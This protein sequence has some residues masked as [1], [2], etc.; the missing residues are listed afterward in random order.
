MVYCSHRVCMGVGSWPQS[1][2]TKQTIFD[3]TLDIRSWLR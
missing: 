2:L 3:A 1:H